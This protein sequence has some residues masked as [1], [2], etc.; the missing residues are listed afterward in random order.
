MSYT[1]A[2]S[3]ADIFG[4]SD[5]FHYVYQPLAGDGEILARVVSVQNTND[6]AK[7]GVMIR[8]D[9][10]AGSPYAMMEILPR[11]S[12]GFQWRLTSGATTLSIGST[13][14]APYWVRLVRAGN[15]ITAYRSADGSNWIQVGSTTVVNMTTNVYVG[16]A[17][18]SHNTAATCTTVFDNVTKIGN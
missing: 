16:L 8:Q 6:Y 9:L 10:T 2:G 3:G 15:A 4:S 13:G 7:A 18:T 12:S 5:K 17:V 1:V 11:K 14:A